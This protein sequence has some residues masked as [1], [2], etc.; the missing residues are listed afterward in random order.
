MERVS[1]MVEVNM[2]ISFEA[3]LKEELPLP[4][5]VKEAFLYQLK[6]CIEKQ[7]DWDATINRVSV[8]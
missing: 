4:D 7:T 5:V 2:G 8:T 1:Y 6:E 3:E